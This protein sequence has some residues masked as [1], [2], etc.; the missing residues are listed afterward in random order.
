MLIDVSDVNTIPVEVKD[1][2]YQSFWHF[3]LLTTSFDNA[4]NDWYILSLTSTCIVLRQIH[5]STYNHILKRNYSNLP[6]LNLLYF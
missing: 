5:Q 4:E 2:I 3:I 1:K 6:T